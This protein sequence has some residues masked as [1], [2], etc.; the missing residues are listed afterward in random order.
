MSSYFDRLSREVAGLT[1]RGV[2]FLREVR[3][4][5]QGM[6]KDIETV[7]EQPELPDD[8]RTLIRS[9]IEQF[10]V[11]ENPSLVDPPKTINDRKMLINESLHVS[12]LVE[13]MHDLF[14]EISARKVNTKHGLIRD[15]PGL[16]TGKV[17][18]DGIRDIWWDGN[19][20]SGMEGYM[21]YRE[22]A[23]VLGY[24]PIE[25]GITP[26]RLLE[27]IKRL[28]DE[29]KLLRRI[30]TGEVWYFADD[31]HDHPESLTAPIIMTAAKLREL[32]AIRES[33]TLIAKE[34]S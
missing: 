7:L 14:H 33:S 16:F 5:E 24:D 19:R 4:I 20:Q 17:L 29:V 22:I 2:D 11:P 27:E 30:P 8:I 3:A 26:E 32:L 10:A 6:L 21:N 23:A 28:A 15:N 18:D 13:H 25:P 34:S 31:G 9:T 12:T 1:V